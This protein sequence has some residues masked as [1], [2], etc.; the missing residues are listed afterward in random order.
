[1][2]V[3]C[4]QNVPIKVEEARSANNTEGKATHRSVKD[5]KMA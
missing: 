5:Q 2:V 1:M 4:N 3:P